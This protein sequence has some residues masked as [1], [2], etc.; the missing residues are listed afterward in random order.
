MY[1]LFETGDPLHVRAAQ[2]VVVDAGELRQPLSWLIVILVCQSFSNLQMIMT[3]RQEGVA[4]GP[5]TEL[6]G[7]VQR[8]I[9]DENLQALSRDD[10]RFLDVVVVHAQQVTQ[11]ALIFSVGAIE[12]S[13]DPL[14]GRALELAIGD[15]WC[16]RACLRQMEPGK[17]RLA[18]EVGERGQLRMRLE[19]AR[20]VAG[21]IQDYQGETFQALV[22]YSWGEGY[23]RLATSRGLYLPD[24]KRYASKALN[25]LPA[26]A[27]VFHRHHYW[28]GYELLA[29][30]A[31]AQ[32]LTLY[33]ADEALSRLDAL[34][35]TADIF[36]PSL[37][38][39]IERA[40]T[41]ALRHKQ[42]GFRQ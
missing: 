22:E 9:S 42:A 34:R 28:E 36:Y 35:A 6:F 1:H 5:R 4:V 26:G 31:E 13:L 14:S 20:R 11:G 16:E 2:A 24:R 12:V 10:C 23:K 7:P 40:A 3:K 8:D 29:R 27:A 18:S 21:G 15:L 32:S 17:V 19:L 30:I 41:V 33:D 37:L 39:K 25:V 38:A